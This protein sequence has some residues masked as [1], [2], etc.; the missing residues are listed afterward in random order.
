MQPITTCQIADLADDLPSPFIDAKIVGEGISQAEYSK[1]SSIRGQAEYVMS[2]TELCEFD[3]CPAEWRK[4]GAEEEGTDST[5]WGT[6]MHCRFLTATDFGERIAVKPEAYENTDGE[7]KPWNGNS[8]ICKQWIKDRAEK[9]IINAKESAESAMALEMLLQEEA[10]YRLR[11]GAR[12]EVVVTAKYYD[13]ETELTIPVRACLDMIPKSKP[14]VIADYKNVRSIH[15]RAWRT[16]VYNNGYHTQ[17]AFYIDIWNAA[18]GEHRDEFRHIVQGNQRPWQ[19]TERMLSQEFLSLGRE[20][21]KR[22]LRR[23][24]HCLKTCEWPVDDLRS[25]DVVVD[26]CLVIGP[27]DWMLMV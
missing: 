8:G 10:I 13:P 9:L 17:A 5:R 19:P 16:Q 14:D 22:M 6:L 15:R 2:R 26:G 25:N 23:Y 12:T 20:T 3:Y 7:T 27:E 24:A 1:Q 21:Y 11:D 4:D 18:S